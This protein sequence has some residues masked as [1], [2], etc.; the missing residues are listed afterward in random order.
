MK[1]PWGL[2][3]SVLIAACMAAGPLLAQETATILGT[4]SDQ[5]GAV[6]PNA[7]V[8]ITNSST[9]ASRSLTT[10]ESGAYNAPD[11]QIG[12]YSLKVD[13]AGFKSYQKNSVVLNVNATV[14]SDI[15]LSVGQ[16]SESITVEANAVQVQS[17]TSEQSNVITGQQIQQI[18]TNGRNPIQLATLVPGAASSLPDF[19]AP[20]A[21]G[22]NNNISFNGER[23]QHNLWMIDGGEAYDR[24]SGGGMIVSPSPDALQEFRV[25]TS[26]YSAQFGAASGGTISMAV[27][28]G[29]RDFHAAAWEFNRNDVFDATDFFANRSGTGKPKLR[30]N[31]YGFNVGGPVFI[32]HLYNKDRQKTFFFYNMEWRKLIQG[33]QLNVT[34]I[35]TAAFGGDF[36]GLGTIT[37][38]QTTDP[39]MLQKYAAAGVTAGQRF[40]GNRIPTSLIDPNAAAFLGTGAFPKANAPNNQFAAAVAVPTDLREEIVRIDHQFNDKLSLMGHLIYDSSSNAYATTLWGSDTYPTVGTLLTAPS[41]S[42]V[43]RLTQSISPTVVNEVSYNFNGNKLNLVPTGTYTRPTGFNVPEYFQSNLLNRLPRIDIGAPY[44]VNYDPGP[45]PWNNVYGA[46]QVGDDLS[47][48][49]GNHNFQFGGS[50]MRSIKTQDISG[51]TN[52]YFGF[53]GSF[54]GNSFAD[55]LLGD[56]NSYQELQLQNATNIAF[57]QYAAYAVDNWRVSTRL[58]L[59]LGLRWEGIPHSYDQNNLVS[60]FVPGQYNPANAATL[61]PNGSLNTAGPGFGTVSSSPLSTVPFYLNGIGLPGQ[62]GFPRGLVQN[63]WNNWGP[64]VGFAYDVAG[65]QKTVIRAGYGMF[66]ERIQGNDIYDMGT[67]P[68]FSYYPNASNVYL[69]NPSINVVNGLQ[70]SVPTY[71]SSLRALAYSDYKVPVATQFSFGVQRQL[72]NSAVLNVSYVGSHGYHQPD[73]RNI[74]TVPLNDPNRIAICGA[75]CG[76]TGANSNYNANF[77]RIYTGYSNIN[78][79]EAATGSNYNSLQA[80]VTWRNSKGLTLSGAYTYS[81]ALDYVSGDTNNVSN[82]FNRNY[83]YG[84]GDFDRR[85]IAVISYVYE[86][87]F[88]KRSTGFKRSVLGGWELSGITMFQTGTPLT[89]TLGYDNLG[90]GGG[91]TNRPNVNGAVSTPQLVDQ[92]FST[93]AFS[94]PGAL[95][96]GNTGRGS[97]RGPGRDNWNIALFKS[98]ALPVREGMRIEFRFETYN[99]FNHTQFN[100]VNTTF[101]DKSNFG[102][103]TSTYDPRIIQ[104]GA[105]FLF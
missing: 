46:H 29:T 49:H 95:Q 48:T 31:A 44:N 52:G 34:A 78:M 88:F 47:W 86:L 66:Y 82:P 67:N 80:S 68:P 98:F 93:A 4:V 35:P 37:V 13:A 57:N 81:H 17:A 2:G 6:V 56:S 105:K 104:L 101:S 9:G 84:S 85:H 15:S 1:V 61:N 77:D 54:T 102:H 36:S 8:T 20:T 23:P 91:T 62:N 25:M 103:V 30:Y 73:V 10:N 90:L 27:R 16:S 53:N 99:T 12:T 65:D 74:N 11:L 39:A 79:T 32:P 40:P 59:N 83:D 38:P 45:R 24:G 22:S 60:N 33:S 21:L 51:Y 43:V 76:Y 28:S 5:S 50:Y 89:P 92:W 72:T 64:R 100:A 7:T 18:D 69:S 26:N 96:W 63:H 55:F 58:T 87:P 14:R 75:N 42:V 94:A 19:N 97:L 41:Y 71:P 70:A 3:R